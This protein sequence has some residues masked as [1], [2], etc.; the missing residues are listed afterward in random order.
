MFASNTQPPKKKNIVDIEPWVC[1]SCGHLL[2]Y[3]IVNCPI[4][5][6]YRGE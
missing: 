1:L 4:C 6:K 5:Y 2:A 3:Y